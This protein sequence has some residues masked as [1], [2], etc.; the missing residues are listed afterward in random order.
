[1]RFAAIL[2]L[3]CVTA[4]TAAPA[5]A[6]GTDAK[7]V[8]R[9]LLQR[10]YQR[11]RRS[12][13]YLARDD[14]VRAAKE[15]RE[16]ER[17]FA[18]LLKQEPRNVQAALLGGQ[19][20]TLAG[21]LRLAARWVERLRLI[22][23]GGAN[24]P[25]YHYLIAFAQ[26]IG[27]ERPERAVRSLTRMFNLNP[28][29]RPVERD[30]LWYRALGDLGSRLVRAKQHEQAIVQF[31]LAVR[32]ARRLGSRPHEYGM[33]AN[34]GTALMESDRY[35][36]ATEVYEG[37]SKADKNNPLWHFRLAVCSANQNR[38][39]DAVPVYREVVRLIDAGHTY[40]GWEADIGMIHLRL[41]NCLRHLADQQRSPQRTAALYRDAET[42]IRRYIKQAPEESVGHKWLGVLLFENL[43]KPYEAYPH[44]AKAHELDPVCDDSLRNMVQILQRYPPPKGTTAEA[45]SARNATLSKDLS[46]GAV[47]RKAA[48]KAREDKNGHDGCN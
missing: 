21:D 5:Q 18:S 46:D 25:D 44:F 39:A 34:I 23:P 28:K 19:A 3:L 10:G 9:N 38:F 35:L 14:K 1:M 17:I 6:R 31:R 43:N 26:L 40:P 45:W 48:R 15:A 13:G 16:A 20:A 32:I 12:E 7:E 29:A 24:A 37:L 4:L 11:L 22:A 27:E 8:G 36:E 47:K 2:C 41:G 42:H 33:L 30:N